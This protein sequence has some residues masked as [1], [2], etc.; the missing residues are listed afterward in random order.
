MKKIFYV[1]SN[2]D[3]KL[4]TYDFISVPKMKYDDVVDRSSFRPDS[5]QIRNFALS[6]TG[7]YGSPVYDKDEPS[8][9]VVR[10]RS[11]KLDK[12]EVGILM[13]YKAE[14]YSKESD[15]KE[16]TRLQKESESIAKSRQDYLDKVT[17]F[18]GVKP[19]GV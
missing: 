13:K 14:Q 9:D 16:K 3:R 4:C 8:D 6:S 5:E 12:A 2:G 17:G 10:I 11:G 15:N 1:D 18:A 7:A 19:Q